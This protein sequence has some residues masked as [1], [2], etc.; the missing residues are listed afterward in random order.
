MPPEFPPLRP[1]PNTELGNFNI[2]GSQRRQGSLSPSPHTSST[3]PLVN[4]GTAACR[5]CPTCTLREISGPQDNT[6]RVTALRVQHNLHKALC[7]K[8]KCNCGTPGW[9]RTGLP[10][11]VQVSVTAAGGKEPLPEKEIIPFY[12]PEPP[13]HLNQPP[14]PKLCLFP[15][16]LC[17]WVD[18][19]LEGNSSSAQGEAVLE[20]RMQ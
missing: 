9:S 16:P 7:W 17:N 3:S 4:T 18:C 6:A 12:T 20:Q 19:F 5:P 10:R 14:N 1:S 8:V 2:Q 15:T 11:S 13:L